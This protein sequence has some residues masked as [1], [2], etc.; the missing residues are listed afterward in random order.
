MDFQVLVLINQPSEFSSMLTA[1][2]YSIYLLCDNLFSFDNYGCYQQQSGSGA[3][4][5]L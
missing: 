4:F 5:D 2:V 3:G 1:D